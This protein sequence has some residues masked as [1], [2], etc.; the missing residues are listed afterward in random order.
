MTDQKTAL[1]TCPFCGEQACWHAGSDNENWA[2]ATC[3]FCGVTLD[4]QDAGCMDEAAKR[5]N[6]RATQPVAACGCGE[7][8]CVEPWEPGCG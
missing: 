4:C 3:K 8:S 6:A 5:W 7:A 2:G 1:M